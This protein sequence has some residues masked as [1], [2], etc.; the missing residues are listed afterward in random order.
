MIDHASSPNKLFTFLGSIGAILIFVLIL[1]VAYLPNR[2]EPIDAAAN[3][4]RQAQA[5]ETRA[6]GQ[7]KITDYAV[8]ADGSV[9]IPIEEAM[10]LILKDY[11]N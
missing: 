5:D 6:A 8:A 2:P 4:A 10:Q 11:R 9:Q 3:A 7:A 1:Y